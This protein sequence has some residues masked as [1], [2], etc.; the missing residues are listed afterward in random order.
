VRYLIEL[1]PPVIDEFSALIELLDLVAAPRGAGRGPRPGFDLV[2]MD[3]A[4]SGHALRLL[5]LPAA[6]HEWVRTLLGILLKYRELT[7][8]GELASELVQL[9]RGLRVLRDRLADRR[10]TSFIIVTRAEE[11]PLAETARLLRALDALGLHTGRVIVN[12]LRDGECS[13]CRIA[14]RSQARAIDRLG[15][16]LRRRRDRECAIIVAPEVVPAPNGARGLVEWA[17][18]WREDA[19]RQSRGRA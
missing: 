8:L 2:V 3:T 6:A 17:S 14:R 11:L 5:E 18:R 9:S 15:V 7:G 1:A 19:A 4:P 12:A 13:A 10:G 16:R